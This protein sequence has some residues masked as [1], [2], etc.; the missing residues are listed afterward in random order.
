MHVGKRKKVKR[1]RFLNIQC[2]K[3]KNKR[4]RRRKK[5]TSFFFFFSSN[6]RRSI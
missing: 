2:S 4:R 6:R 1:N 5:T 3:N